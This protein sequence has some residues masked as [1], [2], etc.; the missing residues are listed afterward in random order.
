MSSDIR[1]RH[2]TRIDL[3][4]I[5]ALEQQA[6]KGEGTEIYTAEHFAAWL[7]TYPDAFFVAEV[8][9][10]IVSMTY[11]F[12]IAYQPGNNLGTFNS[13]TDN[14]FTQATHDPNGNYHFGVTVCSIHRGAGSAIVRTLLNFAAATKKPLLGVSRI[15][16]FDR[17]VTRCEAIYARRIEGELLTDLA[18]HYAIETA[19]LVSGKVALT[20]QPPALPFTAPPL[21]TADPVLR[22][23]LRQ[24]DF[25]I[26]A[27]LPGFIRDPKSRDF[28][29]LIGQEV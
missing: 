20:V 4:A 2:A 21:E 19:T 10:M 5:A 27:P 6:W 9:N 7:N 16:N 13:I 8:G 12:P 23:Y 28:S 15:I 29:I 24:R 26:Y 14:G 18:L 11:A 25:A 22:G 1:I 17:Y 3:A